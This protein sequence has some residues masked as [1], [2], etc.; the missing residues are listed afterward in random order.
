M[1]IIKKGERNEKEKQK[2]TLRVYEMESSFQIHFIDTP[3]SNS[4]TLTQRF[5]KQSQ[6]VRLNCVH[7]HALSR[8]KTGKD[9]KYN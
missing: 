8:A 9:L 7:M 2:K 4:H 1:R 6:E 3:M 5:H